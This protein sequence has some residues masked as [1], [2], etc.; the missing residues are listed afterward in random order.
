V[1]PTRHRHRFADLK[2]ELL[3]RWVAGASTERLDA[4]MRGPLRGVLLWQIFR[5]MRRRFDPDQARGIDAV[6]EFRIRRSRGGRVDRFQVVIADG[7]CTTASAGGGVPTVTLDMGAVTFLR[8]VSGAD[9][10]LRLVLRGRLR[11]GGDLFLAARLPQLLNIP[12]RP[13]DGR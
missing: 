13:G 6:V 8:L 2:A 10:A 9:G 5:T 3:A 1:G 11:V 7:R 4:V 12:R